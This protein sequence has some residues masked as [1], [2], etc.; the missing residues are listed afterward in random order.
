MHYEACCKSISP[1][2]QGFDEK[3]QIQKNTK[4]CKKT[5]NHKEKLPAN[6][7]HNEPE[8]NNLVT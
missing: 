4:N 5:V 1:G 2:P 7:L 8:H 6:L 3:M